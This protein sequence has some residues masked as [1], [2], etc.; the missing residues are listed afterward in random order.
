MEKLIAK[1]GKIEIR[2]VPA[3]VATGYPPCPQF[4]VYGVTAGGDPR[5][6]PSEAMAREIAGL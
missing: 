3:Y 6:C 4:N 5:V 2:E 1:R